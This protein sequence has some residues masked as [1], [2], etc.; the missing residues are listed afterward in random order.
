MAK[1]IAIDIDLTLTTT[2]CWTEEEVQNATP[3]EKV[4][5]KM[6]ELINSWYIVISTARRVEL[7][8]A[9]IKWLYKH[10]VPFNAIDF[11]KTASDLMVDDKA[12]TPDEFIK[13]DFNKGLY[14]REYP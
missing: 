4:I 12:I 2:E 7:A 3:N 9:T 11:R 10:D 8:T 5:E 13:T 14:G 6:R 1:I